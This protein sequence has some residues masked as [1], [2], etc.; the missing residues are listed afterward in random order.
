MLAYPLLFASNQ[1]QMIAVIRNKYARRRRTI[2]FHHLLKFERSYGAWGPLNFEFNRQLTVPTL[3]LTIKIFSRRIFLIINSTEGVL[4]LGQTYPYINNS[5]LEKDNEH[6]YSSTCLIQYAS[7]PL[8]SF[9]NLPNS[10]FRVAA[11]LFNLFFNLRWNTL[12]QH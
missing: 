11:P 9:F 8:D 5:F 10:R 12:A 3:K 2:F 7:I 4:F 1:Q 6:L